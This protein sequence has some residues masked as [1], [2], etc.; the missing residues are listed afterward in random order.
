[1]SILPGTLRG[2]L[3]ALA[4]GAAAASC[5]SERSTVTPPEEDLCTGPA[6]A[7]V[8]VIRNFSFQPAQ[9]RVSPGTRVTWVNCDT[10][11]HTSTADAGGWDSPLLGSGAVFSRT[12]DRAGSF[13]YHCEP[14]P[15][16][17]AS[18][19]VE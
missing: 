1:M 15:F 16:M 3:L 13:A 18:V 2:S 11:P 12:F 5:F 6:R 8:V 10:D 17:T 7:D 19:V 9:L 14:H 4:L